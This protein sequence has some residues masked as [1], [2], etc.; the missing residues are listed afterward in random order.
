MYWYFSEIPCHVLVSANLPERRRF[1]R[2]LD[3]DA[4]DALTAHAFRQLPLTE[5]IDHDG[6]EA[7][8]LEVQV[9]RSELLSIRNLHERCS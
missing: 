5:V 2:G 7:L 1:L 3:G 4:E 9:Y 6:R 8:A